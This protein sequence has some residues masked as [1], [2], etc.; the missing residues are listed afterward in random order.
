MND[1]LRSS[2]LLTRAW[3]S[4]EQRDMA[5]FV[6]DSVRRL[7]F[8]VRKAA[9]RLA[10]IKID[11]GFKRLHDQIMETSAEDLDITFFQDSLDMIGDDKLD[12]QIPAVLVMN[13]VD[14]VTNR[15]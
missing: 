4:I 2:L 15:R 12:T 10:Q 7:D 3:D 14:L 8:E 11:P 6:V 13:K 9:M 1:K 5:I